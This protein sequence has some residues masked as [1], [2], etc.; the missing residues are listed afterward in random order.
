MSDAN[1]I[2]LG[3]ITEIENN[4]I[5]GNNVGNND[6]NSK[7]DAGIVAINYGDGNKIIVTNNTIVNTEIGFHQYFVP[8]IMEFKNNIIKTSGGNAL[9]LSNNPKPDS[10]F[11]KNNYV[12]DAGSSS[13]ITYRSTQ[14]DLSS[15]NS[16][17]F[18]GNDINVDPLFVDESNNDYHLNALSPMINAGIDTELV[19]DI[20]GNPRAG[21]PDI[22]AYDYKEK[23]DIPSDF[24]VQ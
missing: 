14:Y 21:I 4:L 24:R 16:L 3:M 11:D 18:V 12:V 5:Y 1:S 6:P 22:G 10:T 17:P 13:L 20:E 9:W 8:S 2:S 23:I 19:T 15:W 7:E